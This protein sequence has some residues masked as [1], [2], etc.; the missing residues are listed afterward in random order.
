MRNWIH[1]AYLV[2]MFIFI[3]MSYG[4]CWG[5]VAL[6]AHLPKSQW[7]AQATVALVGFIGAFAMALAAG[8]AA[9]GHPGA[10]WNHARPR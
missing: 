1:R 7:F 10:Y 4:L 8:E 6:A 3:G 2:E 9:T 5:G